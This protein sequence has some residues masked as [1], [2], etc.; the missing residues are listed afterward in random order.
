MSFNFKNLTDVDVITSGENLNVIVDNNG[1]VNKMPLPQISSS[2]ALNLVFISSEL[3]TLEE[4]QAPSW[5]A[6]YTF[7]EVYQAFQ[8]RMPISVTIYRVGYNQGEYDEGFILPT[9]V[10]TY[11][12]MIQDT[13]LMSGYPRLQFGNLIVWSEESGIIN[14]ENYYG[15]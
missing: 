14:Y 1:K 4:N 9:I 8:N 6:N 3:E 13:T 15:E 12:L 10:P 11:E 2:N 7:E 5:T